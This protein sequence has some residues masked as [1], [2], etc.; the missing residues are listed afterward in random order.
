MRKSRHSRPCTGEIVR[1]RALANTDRP[2]SPSFHGF[3]TRF[4]LVAAR[5]RR[6]RCPRLGL[7]GRGDPIATPRAA[8]LRRHGAPPRRG[9]AFRRPD[10]LDRPRVAGARVDAA[11]KH[12]GRQREQI[13]A[14]DPQAYVAAIP[15][16]DPPAGKRHDSEPRVCKPHC[17]ARS[18]R[19]PGRL[20][21]GDKR[22]VCKPHCRARSI[23]PPGLF[24]AGMETRFIDKERIESGTTSATIDFG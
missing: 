6:F 5:I 7:R 10:E 22:H 21:S 9:L 23:R 2:A 14:A 11:S 24:V 4:G 12:P 3:A 20:P 15:G 13:T 16:R 1:D 17:R 19:P 8:T 18:M